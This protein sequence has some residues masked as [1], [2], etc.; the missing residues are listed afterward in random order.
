MQLLQQIAFS[1]LNIARLWKHGKPEDADQLQSEVESFCTHA[2]QLG[3]YAGFCPLIPKTH[4][5]LHCVDDL[6][7]FGPASYGTSA[8]SFL[9]DASCSSKC[10]QTGCFV[11]LATCETQHKHGKSAYRRLSRTLLA[12]LLRLTQ[13][14]LRFAFSKWLVRSSVFVLGTIVDNRWLC[15]TY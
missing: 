12:L 5:L 11:L 4:A 1:L 14:Q 15:V 6:K 10:R 7:Y 2:R 9:R 13:K 8:G 3:A